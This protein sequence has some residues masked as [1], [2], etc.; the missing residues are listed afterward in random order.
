MAILSWLEFDFVRHALLA[1]LLLGAFYPLLGVYVV[2]QRVAYFGDAVAHSAFVGAA[3]AAMLGWQLGTVML[4]MAPLF[5]AADGVVPVAH[6]V[7]DRCAAGGRHHGRVGH[8]GLA[9]ASL[10][11]T[12]L[13]LSAL[14]FGDLL[15]Y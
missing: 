3:L 11:E 1:M 12:P 9:L 10:T 5:R 13:A 4:W 2:G 14:L 7:A 15:G 6:A 8:S